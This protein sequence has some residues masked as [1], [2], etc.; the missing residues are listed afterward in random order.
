MIKITIEVI[1]PVFSG[2]KVKTIGRGIIINDGT[3]THRRGNYKFGLGKIQNNY[4]WKTGEIKNFPRLSKN[5]WY[6]LKEV[7]DEA[8]DKKG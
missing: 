7:L 5:V 4:R 8:L 6:L 1:P 3:G 2:K